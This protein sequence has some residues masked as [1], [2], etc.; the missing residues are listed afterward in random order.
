MRRV[1]EFVRG[2]AWF[3]RDQTFVMRVEF[4]R[5]LSLKLTLFAFYGVKNLHGRRDEWGTTHLG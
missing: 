5:I 1:R 4:K 2:S 3:G